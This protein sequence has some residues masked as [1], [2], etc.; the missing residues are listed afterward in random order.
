MVIPVTE[1]A[2]AEG[3]KGFE[4]LGS[5]SQA[6]RMLQRQL[7]VCVCVGGGSEAQ[8]GCPGLESGAPRL[9]WCEKQSPSLDVLFVLLVS[10]P[11]T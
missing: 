6:L 9:P 11:D 10:K 2:E 3:G 8:G 7:C 1:M 4:G 5:K